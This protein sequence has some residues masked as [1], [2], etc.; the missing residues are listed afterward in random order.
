MNVLKLTSRRIS[1]HKLSQI[2]NEHFD[3]RL[4]RS[5]EDEHRHFNLPVTISE[6]SHNLQETDE[7]SIDES[8]E[9]QMAIDED[10]DI[11]VCSVFE[12]KN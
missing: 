4:I 11:E 6:S 5:Y 7:E 12:K 8:L 9:E 3:E 2:L 10:T 1:S